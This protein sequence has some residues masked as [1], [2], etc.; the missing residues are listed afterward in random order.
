MSIILNLLLYVYLNV[1]ESG[2]KGTAESLKYLLDI[3]CPRI[4]DDDEEVIDLLTILERDDV[5]S[6]KILI[7]NKFN[8]Y[9]INTKMFCDANAL[10]CFEY[11]ATINYFSGMKFFSDVL[12]SDKLEF[13]KI[14]IAHKV[15]YDNFS[16]DFSETFSETELYLFK[17]GMKLKNSDEEQD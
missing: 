4:F 10:K 7:E 14:L 2:K 11:L 13:A 6:L 17:H 3:N 5:E 8:L 16:P 9:L 1:V 15:D 12:I